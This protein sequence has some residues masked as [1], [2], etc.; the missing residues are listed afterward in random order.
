MKVII[1]TLLEFFIGSLMFSYWIGLIFKKDIRLI[2]SDGNPGAF[3]LG[4]TLGFKFGVIGALLDFLKGFF[5]LILLRY[6]GFL[7]GW[8]IVLAGI[9]PILGHSFSPFLNFKGGKGVAVTFGVWSAITF[10]EVSLIY[11]LI[12][13]FLEV[14]FRLFKKKVTSE[15]DS[16]V[17][18]FGLVVCLLY[19][20]FRN[21]EIY[22][23]ILLVLNF[24][25]MFYKNKKE[26]SFLLH[27]AG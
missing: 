10:F 6:Y 8:E 4:K 25:V 15:I 26:I 23:L 7:N 9:A 1:I 19:M 17:T 2:A 11:A 18:L 3:N 20:L 27:K 5:P 16:F 22:F 12:L 13:A 21:Y 24:S 14:I